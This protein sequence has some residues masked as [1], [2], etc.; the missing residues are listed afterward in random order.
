MFFT[1]LPMKIVGAAPEI[2]KNCKNEGG[3]IVIRVHRDGDF[4]VYV[5]DD[6]D[7][8]YK[9]KSIYGPYKSE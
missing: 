4:Y 9:I 7:K 2:Y 8:K 6:T 5:L 1:N 3:H